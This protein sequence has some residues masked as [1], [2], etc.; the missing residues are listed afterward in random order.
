MRQTLATAAVSSDAAYEPDMNWTYWHQEGQHCQTRTSVTHSTGHSS[1]SAAER[2][3]LPGCLTSTKLNSLENNKQGS[4]GVLY[5]G[6]HLK[7]STAEG[8]SREHQQLKSK[9]LLVG[10]CCL[11]MA[12][13]ENYVSCCMSHTCPA[14]CT[15]FCMV[16]LW[17]AAILVLL[18]PPPL[19]LL[20]LLL[21]RIKSHCLPAPWAAAFQSSAYCSL[22]GQG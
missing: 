17:P 7:G 19:L 12:Q 15:R 20:L 18:Q 10:C 1:S 16:R 11:A 3:C 22:A 14:S 2:C 9:G 21:L 5:A 6:S 4:Q 13:Q 8:G